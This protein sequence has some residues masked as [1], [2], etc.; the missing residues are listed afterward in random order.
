MVSAE[1]EEPGAG[2]PALRVATFLPAATK[3]RVRDAASGMVWCG[4]VVRT[5]RSAAPARCGRQQ[6]RR[7]WMKCVTDHKQHVCNVYR[8]LLDA[9]L[10]SPQALALSEVV[11]CPSDLPV[12]AALTT[13]HT[14]NLSCR[15]PD[16]VEPLAALIQ[17]QRLRRLTLNLAA[18]PPGR[19]Q[20]PAALSAL[21]ALEALDVGTRNPQWWLEEQVRAQLPHAWCAALTALSSLDLYRVDLPPGQP[22]EPILPSLI[23]LELSDIHDDPTASGLASCSALQELTVEQASAAAGAGR[24]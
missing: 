12:V 18:L 16:A 23:R 22:G 15:L 19:P 9:S 2:G 1:E 4:R 3:L 10:S 14:L 17:L 8:P 6:R 24:R 20:L 7:R 11:L 5:F 13:L 21:S